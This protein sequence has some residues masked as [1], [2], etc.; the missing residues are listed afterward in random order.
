[1]DEID[2]PKIKADCR[3][4]SRST[5]CPAFAGKVR[6]VAPYVLAVEQARTVDVEVD[7]DM[8]AAAVCW[9]ATAPTSR[10]CSPRAPAQVPT[11]ALIEGSRVMVRTRTAASSKS[12]RPIGTANWSSGNRRRPAEG[13]R[14]V[15]RWNAKCESWR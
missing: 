10:S 14:I 8:P 11:A 4:A 6:R 5:R 9:S 12:A 2:A 13:E 1:M 15:V 7:F 3:C